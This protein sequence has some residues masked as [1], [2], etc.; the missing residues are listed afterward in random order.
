MPVSKTE[1]S[2]P[3][4]IGAISANSIAA[5]PRAARTKC[6]IRPGQRE[7]PLR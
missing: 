3:M 1:I 5:E 7:D 2:S 6:N 4:K